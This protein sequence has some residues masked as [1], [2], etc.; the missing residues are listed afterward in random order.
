MIYQEK[1]HNHSKKTKNKEYE[2]RRDIEMSS[3]MKDQEKKD[4][5]KGMGKR[6]S[7]CWRSARNSYH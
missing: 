1:K 5:K 2:W 4:V 7:N 6:I 3:H